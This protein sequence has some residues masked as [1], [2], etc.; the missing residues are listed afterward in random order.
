MTSSKSPTLGGL[1]DCGGPRRR[2]GVGERFF[3]RRTGGVGERFLS[4]RTGGVG[5]RFLSR[6]FG[7]GERRRLGGEGERARRTG[8][9]ERR[10]TGIGDAALARAATRASGS[11]CVLQLLGAGGTGSFGGPPSMLAMI[12]G[13][14]SF[15]PDS[16]MSPI[17]TE[18]GTAKLAGNVGLLPKA[19]LFV[20]RLGGEPGQK[21][22]WRFEPMA[23]RFNTPR[24]TIAVDLPAGRLSTS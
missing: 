4:R 5:D 13:N 20:P 3:S 21:L 14:T 16:S 6:R 11:R 1:T 24:A 9:G 22:S 10:R 7:V 18:Y 8:V 12:S 2:F 19:S 23:G 17:A 15:I